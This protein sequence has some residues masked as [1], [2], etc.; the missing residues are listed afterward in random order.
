MSRIGS[1]GVLL[2]KV[3]LALHGFINWIFPAWR[4]HQKARFLPAPMFESGSMPKFSLQ[5]IQLLRSYSSDH[6][7]AEGQKALPRIEARFL[8]FCSRPEQLCPHRL[9]KSVS[10]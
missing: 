9:R 8:C 3:A 2:A 1:V 5:E 4:T 6:Q 10:P 7:W